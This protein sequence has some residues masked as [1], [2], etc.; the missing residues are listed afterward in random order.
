MSFGLPA[1]R[2]TQDFPSS[3]AYDDAMIDDELR[4]PPVNFL[5]TAF[6]SGILTIIVADKPYQGHVVQ[7]RAY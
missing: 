3:V 5:H 6:V 4:A 2:N 7:G 1:P